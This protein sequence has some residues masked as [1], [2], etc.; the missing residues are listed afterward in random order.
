MSCVA[1]CPAAGALDLTIGLSRKRAAV[2]PWAL[3]VAIVLVF[4]GVVFYARVNGYWHTALPDDM[5]F[6][7]IPRASEFAHPR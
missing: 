6:D 7:L 5:Y 2:P 4:C 3:A 1:V